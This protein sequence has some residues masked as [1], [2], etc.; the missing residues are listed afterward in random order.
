MEERAATMAASVRDPSELEDR[1][2]VD[3]YAFTTAARAKSMWVIK[4]EKIDKAR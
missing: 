2:G 4:Q 1:I 3:L